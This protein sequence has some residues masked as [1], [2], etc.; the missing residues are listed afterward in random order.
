MRADRNGK[1]IATHLPRLLGSVLAVLTFLATHPAFA[2]DALTLS[3]RQFLNGIGYDERSFA[4]EKAT[5]GQQRHLH[6][7]INNRRLSHARKLDL[8]NSYLIAIGIG[9]PLR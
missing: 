8:I 6:R 1:R 4:L 3:D 2:A 9:A 7:L 5:K